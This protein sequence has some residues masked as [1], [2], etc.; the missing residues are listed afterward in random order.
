MNTTEIKHKNVFFKLFITLWS[1]YNRLNVYKAKGKVA[2][3]N[4]SK[5]KKLKKFKV[6]SKNGTITVPKGTKKGAYKVKIKVTAKG[7]ANYKSGSKTVTV[8][9]TVSVSSSTS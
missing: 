2:Y 1:H 9:V 4:V 7:D 3:K 5:A 6:N 8:K